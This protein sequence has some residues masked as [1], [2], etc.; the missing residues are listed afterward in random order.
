M[1]STLDRLAC[2]LRESVQ[3]DPPLGYSAA[4]ATSSPT[5]TC[6]PWR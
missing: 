3:E 6:L 2:Q 5:P 1:I 4:A